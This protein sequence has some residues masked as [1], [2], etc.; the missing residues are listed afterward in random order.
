MKKLAFAFVVLV[1]FL[2]GLKTAFAERFTAGHVINKMTQDERFSF[3]AGMI[4]GM[5]YA[6]YLSDGKKTVGMN[7]IYKWFYD[8]KTSWTHI[9]Q[10]FEKFNSYTPGAVL[11]ALIKKKCGT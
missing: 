10:A 2:G 5:A 7:C 8:D 9:T 3:V 11:G 1:P 6:R 4:E